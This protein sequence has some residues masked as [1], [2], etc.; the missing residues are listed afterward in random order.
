M[1]FR[2]LKLLCTALCVCMVFLGW[3]G[4]I[5]AGLKLA[6]VVPLLHV[7]SPGFER[8]LHMLLYY[9]ISIQFVGTVFSCLVARRQV[10]IPL[11]EVDGL[12]GGKMFHSAFAL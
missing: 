9:S 7:G 3:L 11:G 12:V 6:V 4:G 5:R 2:L 8:P 1:S 10:R